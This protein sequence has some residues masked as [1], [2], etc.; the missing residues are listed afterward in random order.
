MDAKTENPPDVSDEAIRRFLLGELRAPEQ[1]TL[2][3]RLF[4]DQGLE[5]RVRLTESELADDYAFARLGV[6]DRELFEEKFLVSHERER[7]LRVSAALRDRFAPAPAIVRGRIDAAEWLKSQ[8]A[9]NQ[10][11]LKYALGAVILVLIVGTV[12]LL[13]RE[14][15]VNNPAIGRR[16]PSINPSPVERREADHPPGGEESPRH[17]ERPSPMPVHEPGPNLKSPSDAGSVVSVD[18]FPDIS[19]RH[20][21]TPSVPLPQGQNDLVRLSLDLKSKQ[22]EDYRAEVLNSTGQTVFRAESLKPVDGGAKIEFDVPARLLKI[23]RYQVRLSRTSG[24]S[25]QKMVNYYFFVR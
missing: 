9:F 8:F 1:S 4:V 17:A 21:D 12:W 19:P 25:G 18:L 15:R 6:R 13:M 2:E 14:S 22:A 5:E 10:G 11:A 20:A 23:G 24:G 3:E 7:K 16:P